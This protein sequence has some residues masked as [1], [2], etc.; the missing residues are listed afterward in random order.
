MNY[1]I[2]W[3]G[4]AQV[5]DHILDDSIR[6]TAGLGSRGE[7][8]ARGVLSSVSLARRPGRCQ[9]LDDFQREIR[10]WIGGFAPLPTRSGQR[11]HRLSEH[12]SHAR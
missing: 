5:V 12:D 9:D 10:S 4:W 8:A 1:T 7:R 6:E 3:I 11:R 2:S